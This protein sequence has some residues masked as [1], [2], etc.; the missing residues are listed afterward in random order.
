MEH[1]N[2]G[3][4]GRIFPEKQEAVIQKKLGV[5]QENGPV[6]IVII[7]IF[8]VVHHAF[9]S[10]D[11]LEKGFETIALGH[12]DLGNVSTAQAKITEDVP[13]QG[14]KFR[15]AFPAMEDGHGIPVLPDYMWSLAEIVFKVP[16][17][18]V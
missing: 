13:A 12:I 16:A 1:G 10:I 8:M 3:G 7:G 11:R 6:V 17:G 4:K 9:V 2:G 5:H 18:I 15:W 14:G